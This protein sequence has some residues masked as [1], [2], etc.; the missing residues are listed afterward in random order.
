[1]NISKNSIVTVDL[2]NNSS[3]TFIVDTVEGETVLL[4]HPLALGV[5]IR[6]PATTVNTTSANIKDS[7]ERGIDYANSNRQYL[8]HNTSLD[9]EAV[10]IF[11]AL[12]RKLTPRQKHTVANIC[13]SIAS[14]KFNDDLKEVMAFITKNASMLDQFNAM[15]YANFKGLFSGQQMVTSKKQRSAI[16]NI[17]GYLLAELENPTA[18]RRK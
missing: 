6:V 12:K 8:D 18:N 10:A 17:A 3:N 4:T 7:T 5:L 11:F 14:F 2:N 16:F 13:G 1:M 9:L 15:W